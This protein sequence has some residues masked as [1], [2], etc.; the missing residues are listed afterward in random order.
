MGPAKDVVKICIA[1]VTEALVIASGRSSPRVEK[2]QWFA[3]LWIHGILDCHEIRRSCLALCKIT[4][5]PKPNQIR[6]C[7]YLSL[8]LDSS[9]PIT[10][11]YK[12]RNFQNHPWTCFI[13]RIDMR[14]LHFTLVLLLLLPKGVFL[15][16]RLQYD[17]AQ[18]EAVLVR[19]C[20]EGESWASVGRSPGTKHSQ[21]HRCGFRLPC[22]GVRPSTKDVHLMILGWCLLFPPA[23]A[24]LQQYDAVASR[25]F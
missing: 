22:L 1:G 21:A 19:I 11:D 17:Y 16:C 2:T 18:R 14:F 5:T 7:Q 8:A 25:R 10:T 13:H 4:D 23:D 15:V 20:H 24:S 6:E 3:K 12:A 9:R